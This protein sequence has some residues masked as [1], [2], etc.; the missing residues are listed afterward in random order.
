MF[1]NLL[2]FDK[3]VEKLIEVS[4]KTILFIDWN[5]WMVY[6]QKNLDLDQIRN[7]KN[8]KNTY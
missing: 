4:E 6:P 3:I 5:H 2:W 1:F 7:D 8:L